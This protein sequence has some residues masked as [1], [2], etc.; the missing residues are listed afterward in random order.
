MVIMPVTLFN[1]IQ[2][3]FSDYFKGLY[4]R[5]KRLILLSTAILLFSIFVGY[6]Y[7][8]SIDQIMREVLGQMRGKF[9]KE[10]INALSILLNN[11]KASLFIYSGLG[12][13]TAVILFFNG[14]II[15]YVVAIY[16]LSIIY[17]VPHGI[18]EIPAL[19]L[20]AV[21][22]FRIT[23][24]L[25]N[26]LRSLVNDEPL[27]GHYWEFKDSLVIFG[28]AA[29]LFVVAAIIEANVTLSLG[30]YIKSII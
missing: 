25:I 20:A 16:P 13:F 28:I 4:S 19:I 1:K 17:I 15:G 5:N 10:G 2:L 8:N 7:S 11:L 21:A 18:F 22:G 3:N 9:S 27:S 14:I 26:M 23:S 29:L 30:N 12:I 24:M 6:I